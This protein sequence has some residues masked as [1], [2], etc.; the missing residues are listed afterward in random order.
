ML[1][2]ISMKMVNQMKAHIWLGEVCS[3]RPD[4]LQPEIT[5]GN[6]LLAAPNTK[7]TTTLPLNKLALYTLMS[8]LEKYYD[9]NFAAALC[10]WGVFS[11]SGI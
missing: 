9:Y 5:T 11:S 10:Y 1:M 2:F 6:H 4:I 8:T 3:G 7:S